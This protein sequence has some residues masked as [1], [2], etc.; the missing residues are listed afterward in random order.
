VSAIPYAY[1]AAMSVAT[2]MLM[3]AGILYGVPRRTAEVVRNIPDRSS[4]SRLRFR[5]S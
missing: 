5:Y 3:Y 4:T 1:G 2:L